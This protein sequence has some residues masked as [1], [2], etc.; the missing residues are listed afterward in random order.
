MGATLMT[1]W[2]EGIVDN[3]NYTEDT[4]N[5]WEVKWYL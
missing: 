5:K 2:K 4:A 1:E 3:V